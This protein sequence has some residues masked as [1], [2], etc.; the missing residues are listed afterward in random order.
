MEILV[1]AGSLLWVAL[2][3]VPWRPWST[4]ECLQS[5]REEAEMSLCD[6]TVLIPAR[7]ESAVIKRTLLALGNQGNGLQVIL[8]DDQ[9]SDETASVAV[10]TLAAGLL[11]LNGK[12]LPSGWTGKLWALE[13]GWRNARTELILLL[14]ADIELDPGMIGALKQKLIGE[15]LD[16]VSIMARLRMETF[17]EKLLAPAF[18]YFF[19]LLYPFSLGNNPSSALGVAAGGCILVRSEVLRKTGAFGSIR[20]VIIDDCALAASVK[21]SGGRTWTGLSLSVRSHRPYPL[22]SNFWEM[23]ERTA[24]TQL[25]Y[26]I[27][28]LIAT[29]FV[30]VL[31]FWFPW[32]GL[33][34]SSLA[35]R[36]FAVAG[37]CAMISTYMPTLRYYRRAILWAPMLPLVGGLFLLMTWS[38]A[39]RYWSGRRSEWK[40]R[41]YAK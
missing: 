5:G 9:S 39:L 25:R 37:F 3:L 30:M 6:V 23:V 40:G 29:T 8:V 4:R 24:F 36:C 19:K 14:D 31:V 34:S 13:Q 33:L 11:V 20:N 26:S 2:L 38:S 17:W 27:W 28:L 16:L 32:S 21:K 12:A 7:D 1:V 18:I 22:L 35:V 10:S 15:K 41:I